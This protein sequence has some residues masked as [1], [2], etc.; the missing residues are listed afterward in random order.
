MGKKELLAETKEKME[1]A[2]ELL[3]NE[4]ATVRVGRAS[5]SLVENILVEAYGTRM[6]ILELALISTPELNQI[7]IK[8][9]DPGNAEAIKRAV[10]EANLGLNP[11]VDA[12]FIR[13]TIPP[14][15][16]ERRE[17][18]VRLIGQRLEGARI[19]I[20]QIRQEAM[21]KVDQDFEA[22]ELSEDEKFRLRGEIQKIVDEVNE[23]IEDL[24]KA[25][26]QELMEI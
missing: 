25:K 5:S 17:E 18:M 19:S 16:T 7:L 8:S 12:E 26:E 6:R 24:G 23:R 13:I 2:L 14:L 15:T 1:K 9:Y 11:V 22:K 10:L 21:K 20:R 4:L 3:T